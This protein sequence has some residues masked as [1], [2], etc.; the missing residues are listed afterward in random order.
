MSILP[1]PSALARGSYAWMSVVQ[2]YHLCTSLLAQRLG[3]L[4]V[5]LPEHEI[6]MNLLRHPGATQQQIA[7]GCFVAKSG[8]SMLLAKM[9]SSGLVRRDPDK[10]DARI[11]RAY[12]TAKGLK[13]ATKTLK[14]QQ[15]VIELMA[16]PLTDE[17]ISK[18]TAIM[19]SVSGRLRGACAT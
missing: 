7:Q 12:L 1:T 9:D 14:I 17:E 15:E 5:P 11:K 2:S 3:E 16:G 13:L 4:R 8:I 10:T 18:L 19:T 6:L